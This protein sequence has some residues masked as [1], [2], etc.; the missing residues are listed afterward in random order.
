MSTGR[1]TALLVVVALLT[2]GFGYAMVPLY[3][4][5]CEI[6]GI[7]GRTGGQA[8]E[9]EVSELGVDESRWVTV[10]F[11]AN[12]DSGLPWDV[13]PAETFMKVRPGELNETT[14]IM[15]NRASRLNVGQAVPSVAPGRASLYF[16]KTE[17]FCF[18][19]QP[20]SGGETKEMPVRFVI[21][22]RLP[23]KIDMVTL[24]YIMYR[25]EQAAETFAVAN[26]VER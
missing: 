18:E 8:V 10:H 11:D 1:L 2:F 14:Y 20:L 17:C 26:G 13:E 15:H 24:S 25:N 3:N 23:R 5:F 19:A 12:I 6:T 16:N 22:P 4:K 21:D 7:G 9:A